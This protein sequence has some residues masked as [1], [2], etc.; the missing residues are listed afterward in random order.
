MTGWSIAHLK[1]AVAGTGMFCL[2]RWGSMISDLTL[3]HTIAGLLLGL[4][5]ASSLRSAVRHETDELR[6]RLDHFEASVFPLG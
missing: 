3:L 1:L 6:A 2:G 4:L 5:A